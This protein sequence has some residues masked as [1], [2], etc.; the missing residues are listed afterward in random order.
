MR[1]VIGLIFSLVLALC[2]VSQASA[3]SLY[4]EDF[5]VKPE[6]LSRE[7]QL[8]LTKEHA[9]S[10]LKQQLS[11]VEKQNNNYEMDPEYWHLKAMVECKQQK[12]TDALQDITRAIELS[13]AQRGAADD[14][15]VLDRAIIKSKLGMFQAAVED[16]HAVNPS[17]RSIWALSNVLKAGERFSEAD[18]VLKDAVY[19][20]TLDEDL[21]YEGNWQLQQLFA[22]AGGVNPKVPTLRRGSADEIFAAIDAIS[23]LDKLPTGSELRGIL[24]VEWIPNTYDKYQSYKPTTQPCGPF[25]S[26]W[27]ESTDPGLECLHLNVERSVSTIKED[28]IRARYNAKTWEELYPGGISGCSGPERVISSTQGCVDRSFVFPP[29]NR[30]GL[31][32]VIFK[33]TNKA[34]IPKA[35]PQLPLGIS[36]KQF[37]E[38][39]NKVGSASS[40]PMVWT[41]EL[42][43]DKPRQAPHITCGN[44]TFVGYFTDDKAKLVGINIES[45][46]HDA[47]TFWSAVKAVMESVYPSMLQAE[48]DK[49]L[50]EMGLEPGDAPPSTF[51]HFVREGIKF[52]YTPP[53]KQNGCSMHV[54]RDASSP[55]SDLNIA[56]GYAEGPN[57]AEPV[58]PAAQ[59]STPQKSLEELLQSMRIG[60]SSLTEDKSRAALLRQL[61]PSIIRPTV[62]AMSLETANSQ[63]WTSMAAACGPA[64]AAMDLSLQKPLYELL[65]DPHPPVRAAAAFILA[66]VASENNGSLPNS[67]GIKLCGLLEDP[68][69]SVRHTTA[70]VLANISFTNPAVLPALQKALRGDSDPW[71][72]CECAASLGNNLSRQGQKHIDPIVSTLASAVENDESAEVRAAAAGALENADSHRELAIPKLI[73]GLADP[74]AEVH[75]ACLATLARYGSEAQS[76]IPEISKDLDDLSLREVDSYSSALSRF[77]KS[78]SVCLPKLIATIEAHGDDRYREIDGGFVEL[79]RRLQEKAA[80]A[81]PILID[82]LNRDHYDKKRSVIGVLAI[83][84]PQAAAAESA[85]VRIAETDPELKSQ[86]VVALERIRTGS[87]TADQMD[88]QFF[89][90]VY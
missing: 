27:L 20:A 16:C 64:V 52:E 88:Q 12:H 17:W 86:C 35:V 23:R 6:L 47:T 42:V 8:A 84:G 56:P 51:T 1:A 31:M 59:T 25:R 21:S 57:T 72:R 32:S 67:T 78:A 14:N 33:W 28:E 90:W 50:N 24:K 2:A 43:I 29:E 73:L 46:D 58:K 36:P 9:L 15:F 3:I 54:S 75:R 63:A 11:L 65:S 7:M 48:R 22:A 55:L 71:V 74:S 44:E 13:R 85:L 87:G 68:N 70:Q 83:I 19:D 89:G 18:R 5:V 37:A 80:P 77:G 39:F 76:A 79:C 30:I 45:S 69:V 10:T 49:L 38:R 26:V 81:V 62:Q 4:E 41:P 82:M 53:K 60:T 40:P 61:G 66:V 34:L